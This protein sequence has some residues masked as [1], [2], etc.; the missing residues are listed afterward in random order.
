MCVLYL[1]TI[2]KT[3]LFGLSADNEKNNVKVFKFLSVE[4]FYFAFSNV[5]NP[6]YTRPL[7]RGEFL[8]LHQHFVKM[9]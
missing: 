6:R 5:I 4:T 7:S 9:S 1:V 3:L 2:S 8:D